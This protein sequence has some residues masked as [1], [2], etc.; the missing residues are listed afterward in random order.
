MSVIAGVGDGL[1]PGRSDASPHCHTSSLQQKGA[2]VGWVDGI[3][4]IVGG[5][6]TISDLELSSNLE[7]VEDSSNLVYKAISQNKTSRNISRDCK[8]Y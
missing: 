4:A 1:A 2:G 3:A 7:K 8:S 5:R 6:A